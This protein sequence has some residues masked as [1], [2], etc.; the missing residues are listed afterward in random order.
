MNNF[1]KI[2]TLV[3][4]SA[5]LSTSFASA[6]DDEQ[7]EFGSGYEASRKAPS[8]SPTLVLAGVAAAAIVAVL[9]QRTH[10]GHA[11]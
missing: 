10:H 3:S 8:V 6:A 9:V 1:K 2:M 11:H 5:I 4:L 7:Y